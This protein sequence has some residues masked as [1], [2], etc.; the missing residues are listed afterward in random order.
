MRLILGL[1]VVVVGCTEPNPGFVT[2]TTGASSSGPGGSSSTDPTRATT[3]TTD[4]G[5]TTEPVT[6]GPSMTVGSSDPGTSTTVGDTTM[7]VSD[8]GGSTLADGSSTG[9][10]LPACMLAVDPEAPLFEVLKAGNPATSLS[11]PDCANFAGKLYFAKYKIDNNGLYFYNDPNCQTLPFNVKIATPGIGPGGFFGA[12]TCVDVTISAYAHNGACWLR[13]IQIAHELDTFAWGEFDVE[14]TLSF[15]QIPVEPHQ[16]EACGCLDC[17]NT[18]PGQYKF[19]AG[20]G[21]AYEAMPPVEVFDPMQAKYLLYNVR[22][23]VH[24]TCDDALE[25]S[26]RHLDYFITRLAQ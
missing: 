1:T 19:V 20:N 15:N 7:M 8:T 26:W 18:A 6:T 5:T 21:A 22:S 3:G 12:S 2:D 13:S 23:H 17:C 14:P 24:D 10:P 4:P 16:L 11:E 25:A 9:D